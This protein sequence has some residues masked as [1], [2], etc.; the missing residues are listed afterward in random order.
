MKKAIAVALA[1]GLLLPGTMG[2]E[3]A[4]AAPAVSAQAAIVYHPDSGTALFAQNADTSML[5]ASTT[6]LM[7]ALVVL[8]NCDPSEKVE[9][10]WEHAS[11]EGSSMYL[12]P[13]GDYTVEELLY[14]FLLASGDDAALAL[15][16]HAGG[17]VEA[18]AEMM[19]ETA[20]EL[21]LTGSSFVNPHGLDDENQ[22][23]TARDLAVIMAAAMEDELF[24]EIISTRSYTTHDLTYVNHNK[25][26]WTCEGVVGGKTGY[27]MAAG[28]TLVSCC[29]RDGMKLICVTLSDPD[30]W[31][32]H[33]ALYD[34]AYENYCDGPVLNPGEYTRVP[35]LSGTA[36]SVGVAPAGELGVLRA[37]GAALSLEVSLPRFVYASIQAGQLAGSITVYVDGAQ[38]LVIPLHY[39]ESVAVDKSVPLSAWERLQRSWY[40]VNRYGYIY[41]NLS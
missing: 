18:F 30:D 33:S 39:I 29:I 31:N 26:L 27:T 9:V 23:S 12:Q 19:N 15:A 25:L 5:I 7:T 21:G 24:C 38:A 13:G 17:T 32:D 40:M 16:C 10:T 4:A 28:R 6:K 20:A 37:K 36:E 22:Y 14:G 2:A 35:V 3:A 11:V 8:E 34:W 1:L 41:S